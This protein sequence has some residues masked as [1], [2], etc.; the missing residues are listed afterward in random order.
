MEG[1]FYIEERGMI[2]VKQNKPQGRKEESLTLQAVPASSL[3]HEKSEIPPIQTT[4]AGGEEIEESLEEFELETEEEIGAEEEEVRVEKSIQEEVPYQPQDI[5]LEYLKGLEKISLLTPEKE[6]ELAKR[7]KE[8]ERQVK[9]LETKTNRLKAKMYS[10]VP[11]NGNKKP[12]GMIVAITKAIPVSC[13][14]SIGVY[15]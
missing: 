11:K 14:D 1:V 8:G 3:F 13:K 9:L 12:S 6:V 2:S 4:S 15:A 7:I 10:P 5:T